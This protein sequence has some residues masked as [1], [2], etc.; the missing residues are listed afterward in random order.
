MQKNILN[1][2]KD[3]VQVELDKKV[4][5]EADNF[6]LNI[7]SSVDVISLN[8]EDVVALIKNKLD[9]YNS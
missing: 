4:G 9:I 7:K 6:N 2:D 5:D 8:S 1:L 3:S